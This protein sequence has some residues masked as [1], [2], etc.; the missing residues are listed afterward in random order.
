MCILTCLCS[1]FLL[2]LR[3][4]IHRTGYRF[5]L[6]HHPDGWVHLVMRLASS[7]DRWPTPTTRMCKSMKYILVRDLLHS[8]SETCYIALPCYQFPHSTSMLSVSTRIWT[9]RIGPTVR[10]EHSP[11]PF[12][13]LAYLDFRRCRISN[14]VKDPIYPQIKM[15]RRVKLNQCCE[16]GAGAGPLSAS[17]KSHRVLTDHPSML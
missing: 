9:I 1:F 17:P 16:H 7:S 12:P 13:L 2:F 15:Q 11:G 14:F 4:G 3:D 6:I 10:I 8:T 5:N